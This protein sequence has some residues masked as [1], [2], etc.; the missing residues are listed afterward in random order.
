MSS[1]LENSKYLLSNLDVENGKQEIIEIKCGLKYDYQA[2]R[3]NVIVGILENKS[4][5]GG[6]QCGSADG[7]LDSNLQSSRFNPRANK[8]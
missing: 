4:I 2:S 8:I 5:S 6:W 1:M 7:V 3:R